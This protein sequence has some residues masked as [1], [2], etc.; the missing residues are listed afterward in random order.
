[1]RRTDIVMTEALKSFLEFD[2]GH[3]D[4]SKFPNVVKDVVYSEDD[5]L[6]LDIYYPDEVKDKYPVFLIIYGGGWISGFKT[7]GFIEPMLKPLNHGYV[8]IVMDYTLSLDEAFPRSVIDIKKGIDFIH[9][10]KDKYKFDDDDISIWGESAGAHLALEAAIVPNEEL[11]I[12]VN[13]TVKNMVIFYPLVNLETV[14][15]QGKGKCDM[16]HDA[17]DAIFGIYMGSNLRNKAMRKLASPVNYVNEKMPNL[18][19]QHGS[20]DKLLPF[21]QT[22]ELGKAVE[23]IDIKK[24]IEVVESKEHTDPYFFTDENVADIVRFIEG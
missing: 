3:M 6:K 14:D 12:N 1:M 2:L 13:S 8:C 23:G 15:V 9:R 11:G 24:H 16:I 20:S 10:E 4:E 18:W 22:L 5:R 19:L 21:E 17:E 7:D